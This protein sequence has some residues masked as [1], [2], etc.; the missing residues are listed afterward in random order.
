MLSRV[1]LFA[2][3]CQAFLSITNSWSL[4][5][6]ISIELV[7]P[8]NHLIFCRPLLLPPSIFPS[9]RSLLTSQFFASG[10]QS[11]G[12]SA[13]ASV[14]PMNI[15]DRFPLRWIGLILRV[16]R[17]PDLTSMM[18]ISHVPVFRGGGVHHP[19]LEENQKV[20]SPGWG[21]VTSPLGDR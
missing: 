9:I 6:L 17:S 12:A 4:L 11:T 3:P 5:K 16:F 10:G 2:T 7:M 13:S 14:L 18:I 15:Q 8:S 1:L 21:P 19:S 20:S